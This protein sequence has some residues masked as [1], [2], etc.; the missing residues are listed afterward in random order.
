MDRRAFL[1]FIA[2][3]LQAVGRIYDAAGIQASDE[4]WQSMAKWV[5]EHPRQDLSRPRTADLGPYGIDPDEARERF[6]E[7][8]NRY[9]LEYDGL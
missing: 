7:Y 5:D 1:G 9:E 3:P 4:V 6:S 8:V 2:D